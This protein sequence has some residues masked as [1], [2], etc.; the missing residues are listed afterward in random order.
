[1]RQLFDKDTSTYTYLVYDCAVREGVLIDPVLE[2]A[3]R[4]LKLADELGIK[5][6][7]GLNTHLH[8]DHIT[9]T[10]VLKRNG[11]RSVLG[12]RGNEHAVADV[13]LDTGAI[14]RV[15]GVALEVRHTPGHTAGC[16]SYV[17]LDAKTGNPRAVFTGDALLIRGC[18]RTDFQGGSST[19]LYHSV[20]SHLFTLPDDVVVW[21]AHDYKGFTSSTIG[22]ERVC[23]PRLSKS[24]DQFV[25]I[26]A[27]A[28]LRFPLE[29]R[30][31]VAADVNSA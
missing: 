30:S 16:H 8:A 19:A 28:R 20:H 4:D 13:K 15:G 25:N 18:G 11:V 6:S 29:W 5:I 3:D 9:A 12:K 21:P 1:V 24:L 14:L 7:H 2:H 10:G 23:N 17:L 27:G 26:M 22:E 31:H